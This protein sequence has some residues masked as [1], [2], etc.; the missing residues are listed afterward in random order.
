MKGVVFGSLLLAALLGAAVI[1]AN[2][3]TAAGALKTEASF[4]VVA[5][6]EGDL[7]GAVIDES[8]SRRQTKLAKFRWDGEM[9]QYEGTYDPKKYTPKQ[10]ENTR[11]LWSTNEFDLETFKATAFTIDDIP[12]LLTVEQLQADY[13]KRLAELEKLEVVNTPYWQEFKRRKIVSLG[14]QLALAKSS[15]LAYSNP[16]AMRDVKFG[17]ACFARFADPVISGGDSMLA[18]WKNL[19]IEMRKRN[20]DPENVRRQYESRLASAQKFDYAK[21]DLVTFGWW[22]C[23]NEFVDRGDDWAVMSKNYDKLFVRVREYNCEE[24]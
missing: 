24:P 12:N 14:Q 22:N 17:E 2:V 10:L 9:C 4:P 15:V 6:S 13:D 18:A 11:R 5:F 8:D 7:V 1:G 16:S 23:V 19:N 20:G 3:G 21:V